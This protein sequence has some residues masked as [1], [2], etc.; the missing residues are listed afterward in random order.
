MAGIGIRTIFEGHFLRIFEYLNIRKDSKDNRDCIDS[1]ASRDC[2]DSNDSSDCSD[3]RD[4]RGR[5]DRRDSRECWDISDNA[6][7][8][9]PF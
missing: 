3:S 6:R 4:I 9:K 2:S 7:P 1:I 5:S 8:L